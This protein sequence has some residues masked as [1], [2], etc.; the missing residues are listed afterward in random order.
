MT[1]NDYRDIG[2]YNPSEF[3][4]DIGYARSFGPKFSLGGAL[5]FIRSN[6]FSGVMTTGARAKADK[7]LAADVSAMYRD[8]A[9]YLAPHLYYLSD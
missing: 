3:A 4:L 9:T 2:V 5:R 8:E 7:A 1:D 6:L